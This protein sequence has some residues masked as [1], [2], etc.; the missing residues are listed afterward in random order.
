MAIM[1]KGKVIATDGL[2]DGMDLFTDSEDNK[3]NYCFRDGKAFKKYREIFKRYNNSRI[4]I[5]DNETVEAYSIIKIKKFNELSDLYEINKNE[6][7][8]FPINRII[9]SWKKP[10]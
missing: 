4:Y 7:V 9:L 2:E 8:D 3:K 6:I 10:N 1:N 5:P